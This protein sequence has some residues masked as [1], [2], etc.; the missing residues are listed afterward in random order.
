MQNTSGDYNTFVGTSAGTQN[1][2]GAENTFL[3]FGAGRLTNSRGNTML[4]ALSGFNNTTGQFNTFV[5]DQAGVNN[6]SGSSNFMMV[7]I[8]AVVTRLARPTFSW[9]TTPEGEIPQADIM[10]T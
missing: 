9:A 6:T 5:G 4:G 8:R 10:S 3:G 7:L 2:T 1:V